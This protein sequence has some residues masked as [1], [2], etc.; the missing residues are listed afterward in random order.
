MEDGCEPQVSSD[1]LRKEQGT[2]CPVERTT[3]GK[4]S[5]TTEENGT[6]DSEREITIE[7]LDLFNRSNDLH[8]MIRSVIELLKSWSDCEAVG[9][10]LKQ[11]DDYPYYQT[12]GFPEAFVEME[13]SL[14]I[15]DIND[16]ISRDDTGNPV[17]ECMCGNVI[18]G[19]I[20]DQRTFFTRKGSFWT[21]STSELLANTCEE[22]RQVRTRNRCNGEGYESVALIPL[23]ADRE[24]FGLIQL[25]DHRKGMFSKKRIDLIERLADSIALA[26][27]Q[28]H[29]KMELQLSEKRMKSIFKA[30]PVGIGVV[31]NRILTEVNSKICEMTGYEPEELIGSSSRIL[32]PSNEEYEYVGSEKYRQIAEDGTG[33]VET[34][35]EKKDGTIIDILL[36]ST[37]IDPNDLHSGV[38]FTALDITERKNAEDTLRTMAETAVSP[39]EDIFRIIVRQL[40]V[41]QKVPVAILASIEP[42][43]SAIASTMAV[44]NNGEYVDNFSYD[45]NGTP[46]HN[47]TNNGPCFYPSGIKELFPKDEMLKEIN[48]ESYWGT[49]L[50]DSDGKNIGLLLILDNKPMEHSTRTHSILNSF[51]ARAAAE[52][53]RKRAEEALRENERKFRSYVDNSPTSIFVI[54]KNGHYVDVN[55]A[56]SQITGY[57]REELLSM[58]L[59][60][61]SPDDDKDNC[62]SL[63]QELIEKNSLSAEM[64]FVRKEGTHGYWS[65]DAI[66]LSDEHYLGI[67][68]D[69][70]DRIIAEEMLH[71]ATQRLTIAT[72][73]AGIGIWELDLG[74]NSIIWDRQMHALYG[75]EWSETHGTHDHWKSMIH[76]DDLQE[77]NRT[78]EGSIN[79][80]REH[81]NEFRIIRPDGEVR[82]IEAHWVVK[83]DRNGK[84]LK[85]IGTNW[86]IT[87]RKLSEQ[88]LIDSEGKLELAMETFGLGFWELDL[89]TNMLFQSPQM[90]EMIGLGPDHQFDDIELYLARIHQDD[91]KI[92]ASE[93]SK[94]IETNS[95]FNLD[96]R[97]EHLS[98]EWL[99]ISLK[100]KPFGTSENGK[101]HRIIGTQ[102]DITPRVKAE[103][104][105]LY[106]KIMADDAN[107][108]KSEFMKNMSHE[109]RTPL[110]A[111]IGFSDVLLDQDCEG[112]SDSQRN[113]VRYIH[114]SGNSLL[115]LINRILDFSKY[116]IDDPD[117]ITLKMLS[118]DTFINERTKIM[119]QRA[120]KKNIKFT[121]KRKDSI[122][123][124][125][126]DEDK[127][128]QIIHNLLDN[129]LKFT[130][131]GGSVTVETKEHG[132]MLQVSVMDTGIGIEKE[133]I[134]KI[135]KPFVQI[136]GSV[137]RKYSG[138]GIGLA[139][140]KKFVELHNGNI[141]V[142]SEPG[143]GSRFTFEIPT[144]PR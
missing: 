82:F 59:M 138:T 112:L 40:A 77:V 132:N 125:Y 119:S 24:I 74:T 27:A 34:R 75:T 30:A 88:N 58:D 118:F 84:P 70:T 53:E 31:S 22:D 86:D 108:I 72:R 11:G 9:I 117:R 81:D 91:R 136:D 131:E 124:F 120:S 79:G 41:S 123:K 101:P 50:K 64:P 76:P 115:E 49:P 129:A 38:T 99:W 98:G 116:E 100:G 142:D 44:W 25:N 69:I 89:N 12:E 42:E 121:V 83:H 66:K 23:H 144:D 33:T 28:K 135:F 35:W 93:F 14:C 16:Q 6:D 114:H 133:M 141:M 2:A 15:K 107:R 13:N 111:V 139:L 105:L 90:N 143:K 18:C 60:D 56:S 54:D 92:V 65:F 95:S 109:L 47:V 63:F 39:G 140:T 19:R 57:S 7:L 104:A 48:A 55:P 94:A 26:L 52:M 43:G 137:A 130:T 36:S 5:G 1:H 113:Y 78:I 73:S 61:L 110:T 126:A 32:Y 128:T 37:P 80:K 102:V 87:D 67:H 122:K 17:L 29:A 103:E 97:I 68:N 21:N 4:W 85:I 127:L 71:A 8:D 10:R 106:S 62:L 51:A 20:D 96:C 45:T 46:C 134:G 3:S